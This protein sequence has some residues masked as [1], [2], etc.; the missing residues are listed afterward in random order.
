VGHSLVIAAPELEGRRVR[1]LV[2]RVAGQEGTVRATYRDGGCGC[3][4][5]VVRLEGG[6]EWAGKRSEAELLE[7]IRTR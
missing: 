5:L 7:P 2:G 4:Q 1:V 6:R 3:L